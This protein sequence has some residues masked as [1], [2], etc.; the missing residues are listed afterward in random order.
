M[1]NHETWTGGCLCGRVAFELHGPLGPTTHCHCRSCRRS[2]GAAFITWTSV[3]PDQFHV[4]SGINELAWY[5]SSPGVRWAFCRNCGASM[6]YVA[7]LPGHPDAPQLGH[8]YVSAGSLDDDTRIQPSAHVSY[9][10][11]V[12]WI[13]GA[14][15][16]P[17]HYGKT[18]ERMD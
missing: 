1:E 13:E 4:R 15:A 6:L 8:I 12:R 5:R 17:R 3:A 11:R 7:D 2:H 14:D 10:E 9:E 16:L 18:P